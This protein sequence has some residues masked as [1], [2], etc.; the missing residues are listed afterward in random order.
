MDIILDSTVR[1]KQRYNDVVATAVCAAFL[2]ADLTNEFNQCNAFCEEMKA[3]ARAFSSKFNWTLRFFAFLLQRI[4]S[5]F[6]L[7]INCLN[8]LL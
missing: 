6:L 5:R 3:R 8:K 4:P 1:G 2:Q 7:Q